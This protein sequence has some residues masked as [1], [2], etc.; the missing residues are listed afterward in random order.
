MKATQYILFL[1]ANME[2][3]QS[4][5]NVERNL[6]SA[7]ERKPEALHIVAP[8]RIE[9]SLFGNF[10]DEIVVASNVGGERVRVQNRNIGVTKVAQRLRLNIATVSEC[11]SVV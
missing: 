3:A 11:V 10:V 2:E 4:R 7:L 6:N 9:S 5:H 8:K 1:I